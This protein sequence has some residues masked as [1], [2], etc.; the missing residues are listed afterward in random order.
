MTENIK[1]EVFLSEE[2]KRRPLGNRYFEN[3]RT[4][5]N[6]Y[7]EDK[8]ISPNRQTKIVGLAE[9][10]SEREMTYQEASNKGRLSEDEQSLL[11]T[12]VQIKREIGLAT[13]EGTL[14]TPE[15]ENW[16][17]E[18]GFKFEEKHE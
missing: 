3:F 13:E 15:A 12:F 8:K 1:E 6:R 10:M 17:K 4:R 5:I 14:S 18:F 2:K 16:K 9:A 11:T 7:V